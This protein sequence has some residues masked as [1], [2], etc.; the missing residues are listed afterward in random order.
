MD[1]QVSAPAVHED[2]RGDQLLVAYLIAKPGQT[3]TTEALR[4]GLEAE[5]PPYNSG[6][7][8]PFH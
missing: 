8:K 3:T 4:N 1:P 6:S 5:L 7:W 2:K